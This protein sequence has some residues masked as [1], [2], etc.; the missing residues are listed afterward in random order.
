MAWGGGECSIGRPGRGRGA[1]SLV[2]A[3]P[4]PP[5]RALSPPLLWQGRGIKIPGL[6]SVSQ[7][8]SVLSQS[9]QREP[10][11]PTR[12]FV[13]P[14]T[15]LSVAV[16]RAGPSLAGASRGAGWGIWAQISKNQRKTHPP[17]AGFLCLRSDSPLVFALG[18]TI[19]GVCHYTLT[20]KGSHL[21]THGALTESRGWSKVWTLFFVEVSLGRGGSRCGA[22]V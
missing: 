1:C 4:G 22:L 17:P 19:L 16:P 20:V 12:A 18:I 2:L 10:T 13:E 15:P 7:W 21:A 8:L 3:W 14:A 11:H 5:Y 6:S 9:L